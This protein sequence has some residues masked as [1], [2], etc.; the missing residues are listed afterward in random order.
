LRFICAAAENGV[1]SDM[2]GLHAPDG[3]IISPE[4]AMMWSDDPRIW[5]PLRGG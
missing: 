3:S 1:Y 5:Q 4:A 2:N